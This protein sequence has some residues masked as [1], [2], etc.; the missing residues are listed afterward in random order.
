[1][2]ISLP[3]SPTNGQTVQIGTI[4]Y[5]YNATAGVW[6]SASTSG[7]SSIVHTSDTAPSNPNDGDMWFDSS[8]GKTFI[9]YNDG[10]SS[11]WI[12]MNPNT[13]GSGGGANLGSVS[14]S[15]I[16]DTDI[17]Y[18]LGSSSKKFKDLYLSG[19]T[20]NLGNQS[21][22][23]T[24]T[25]IVVPELQIGSGTNNVKLTTNTFGNLITTETD[26]SG[27]SGGASPAG[28]AATI[29]ADMAGLIAL[30]GMSAGSQ[31]YV[32]AN[33]KLYFYTGSGWYIIATVQNDAPSAITGV[34]GSYSL[35]IDGTA[36]T[37]TAVSTDP[38]GFALTWSYTA[39][40]LGSIATVS[41]ADNVFTVTPSTDAAN[42][43]SFTLNISATDGI[44]GAVSTVP[45]F[46][47]S[48]S[49]TNSR[50][51][52]LSVKATAAGSNQTF[53]DAS[54]SNLTITTNGDVTASTFSPYRQGGY[55]LGLDGT[56]DYITIPQTT[57]TD[58]TGDFTVEMWVYFNQLKNQGLI[59]KW[60]GSGLFG[61][62]L[63]NTG[64]S[65]VFVCSSGSGAGT[66]TNFTQTP[67][68]NEWL[69]IA[70]SR[71]SGTLSTYINGTRTTTNTASENCTANTT[72]T[73]GSDG[74]SLSAWSFD[75]YMR[76]VRIVNGT[77]LYTGT[78]ITVPTVPL[79]A[80]TNTKFLLGDLP[81]LKDQSTSNHAITVGGNACLKPFSLFDNAIY[82][83]AS[84][85]AS[86]SFGTANGGAILPSSGVSVGSGDYTIEFWMNTNKSGTQT[87]IGEPGH[88]LLLINGTFYDWASNGTQTQ[89]AIGG[90]VWYY[91]LN[92]WVHI[93]V[94]RTSGVIKAWING[95]GTSNTVSDSTAWSMTRIGSNGNASSENFEGH[96]S[97]LRIVTGT[98]VYSADFTPPT[99]PLTAIT[100]TTFLLNPE[101]SISDLSQSSAITCFGNAATSTTQ[102][103]FAG[104]KSIYFDGTGDYISAENDAG[105]SFG[106][107]DF[108]VESW[109]YHQNASATYYD[110]IGTAKNSGYMGS[111]RGGWIFA[112]YHTHGST[113]ALRFGYQYNNAFPDDIVFSKTL[114]V[115]TWYHIAMTRQGNQLKCFVDG[116]QVGSTVTNSTNLFSTEPLN[117]G[118][119]S[120]ISTYVTGY[121]QDVRITKGLARYTANFTPPTA[122]LQG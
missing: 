76:D 58:L 80:V 87:L 6:N 119:G 121:M 105:F 100:N 27:N 8:I 5:T 16:P 26:S 71:T 120:G 47:L 7:A 94:T 114:N 51:T 99:A 62:T 21:I 79:T 61:W 98:A 28:G 2:P 106:T 68:I 29:V 60:S 118:T 88:R 20:L 41:Q 52:S 113:Y 101:T 32:T 49:V 78:S 31:A 95:A 104:T 116:V 107:G 48:F 89:W 110:L 23:A 67:A 75:G 53:D 17:T 64:T 24:A 117:I 96:M 11:Q 70:V 103:K 34:D 77:G 74:S 45:S 40:G 81:Y 39:S 102:V 122:E 92:T 115:D 66:S 111:N 108:T 36:T 9:W 63:Y 37:I 109:L 72:L 12:Q 25:G 86:V 42:V 44:N 14:E 15:I 93:A 112:Y 13:G 1:M 22:S 84:H 65:L 56:N 55:S 43:G 46:V 3:D 85:G 90:A 82:S 30:T 57:D 10:S 18:D 19:S 35:A 38:E 59:G 54:A 97:D 73:V 91:T 50:Y 4:V 33:N 83:E 69:H